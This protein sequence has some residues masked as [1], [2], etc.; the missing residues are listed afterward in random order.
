MTH[1][2]NSIPELLTV[3]HLWNSNPELLTP[4]NL[5]NSNPE[6]LGLTVPTVSADLKQH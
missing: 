4:T 5:W 1:L 6:L 2:W 3:T